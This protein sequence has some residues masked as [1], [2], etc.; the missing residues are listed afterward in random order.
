MIR[1]A[2]SADAFAT[3]ALSGELDRARLEPR[4]AAFATELTLGVLR[5]QHRLDVALAAAS[6]TGRVDVST[7]IRAIMRVGAYEI[8]FCDGIPARAS[9]NEAAQAARSVAGS[10]MAGFTNALLRKLASAGEPPF[11]SE[12]RQRIS[13]EHSL[14]EWLVV[15][16]EAA[17]GDELEA[18]AAALSSVPPICLR[19]NRTR[20]TPSALA[21]RLSSEAPGAEIESHP[22]AQGA[23]RTRRLGSIAALSSFHDGLFTVQDAAAQRVSELVTPAGVDSI[24]DACAGVGGKTTHLAELFGPDVA[25]DAVDIA[26]GKL[27]RLVESAERLGLGSIRK[28]IAAD[29]TV[30]APLDHHYDAVVLDAPCS[31]LGVLR[32]HPEAKWRLGPGHSAKLAALQTKMLEVCADL[33]APG[34]QL[35]YAVCTFAQREG[36]DQTCDFAARHPEFEISAEMTS[37]PHRDDAD[38]FYAARLVRRL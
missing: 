10:K 34:G 18:A 20:T 38:A 4:D 23:L 30:E 29:I 9:V 8:L 3:L 25:I 15:E 6:K 7:K 17:A 13:I 33:V 28:T 1:R 21:S 14:P 27:E 16:L 36:R 5:H 32:R 24:L 19:P 31:G 22:F 2:G 35:I 26:A 37:W 12:L 11:P